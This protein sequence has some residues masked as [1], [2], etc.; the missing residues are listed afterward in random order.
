[1][2]HR[3]EASMKPPHCTFIITWISELNVGWGMIVY[4]LGMN[5]IVKWSIIPLLKWLLLIAIWRL[6]FQLI[7]KVLLQT[8]KDMMFWWKMTAIGFFSHKINM[9]WWIKDCELRKYSFVLGTFFLES[10]CFGMND[11]FIS[12][13]IAKQKVFKL[14]VIHPCFIQTF[15]IDYFF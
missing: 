9:H 12:I 8:E 13:S 11:F 2:K 7:T 3:Y 1:M 15:T 14:I 6:L 10:F 5:W 4:P